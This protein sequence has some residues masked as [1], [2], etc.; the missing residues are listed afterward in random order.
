MKM[1]FTWDEAGGS[2]DLPQEKAFLYF[3]METAAFKSAPQSRTAPSYDNVANLRILAFRQKGDRFLY[4]GDVDKSGIVYDGKA[5]TGKALL[6]TGIYRFIPAYG[7][8]GPEDAGYTLSKI[9]YS[10]SYTDNLMVSHLE[11]G[12]LPV[13]FLQQ[14]NVPVNDYVLGLDSKE[15]NPTVSLNLIR[16]IARLDIL[17]VRGGR[18]E[19]GKY[20]EEEGAVF[21]TNT[22][23]A[24]LT[25][26]VDG[27]NPSVRLVDGALVAENIT[28]LKTQYVMDLSTARTNGTSAAT[29]YGQSSSDGSA[30]DYEA[31][32]PEDFIDGSAHIY[33]PFLFPHA[34]AD[35]RGCGLTLTLTSTPDK[36][37]GEVYTR[38]IRLKQVPLNRNKVTLVKIYSGG[39]D[40]FHTTTDFEII[41]NEAWDEHQEIS[42]GV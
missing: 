4:I 34:E 38:T 16:A 27:V 41:V 8:P 25:L 37:N 28:P 2:P 42:G 24:A 3:H 36:I 39:K 20:V 7:L 35:V 13:L 29:T 17:F 10:T 9:D 33:G 15:N 23:L 21:G 19:S 11:N 6:P 1:S 5:F 26:A 31:M 12:V 22:D 18:N 40:I 32:A 14:G 30:Y